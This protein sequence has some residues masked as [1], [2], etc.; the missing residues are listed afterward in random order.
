MDTDELAYA[1][2]LAHEHDRYRAALIEIARAPNLPTARML[3]R[4][5]LEPTP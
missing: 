2:E 5:A 1:L 3:A 4:A